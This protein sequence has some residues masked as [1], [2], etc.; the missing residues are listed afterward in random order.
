MAMRWITKAKYFYFN[1]FNWILQSKNYFTSV[2]TN[3][4][5]K[6]EKELFMKNI[7]E[8]KF[9]NTLQNLLANKKSKKS[10]QKS[11]F[12]NKTLNV[13]VIPVLGTGKPFLILSF[14]SMNFYINP[15]GEFLTHLYDI[16]RIP[17]ASSIL[18]TNCSY[19][20]A[21][22]VMPSMLVNERLLTET[23]NVFGPAG[24]RTTFSKLMPRLKSVKACNHWKSKLIYH[25]PLSSGVLE[26]NKNPITIKMLSCNYKA[27]PYVVGY[28]FEYK[29]PR[30]KKLKVSDKVFQ[31]TW[32]DF[33]TVASYMEYVKHCRN[34]TL[35]S[36]PE[37]E[38]VSFGVLDFS[39]QN[40]FEHF[41]NV[42]YS[43][44]EKELKKVTCCIHIMSKSLF[45]STKYTTWL[46]KL[47][48]CGHF[49]VQDLFRFSEFP[50]KSQNYRAFLHTMHPS[51]FPLYSN[52]ES[53]ENLI[54]AMYGALQSCQS[55]EIQH[56]AGQSNVKLQQFYD[57]SLQRI[58]Q[59]LQKCQKRPAFQRFQSHEL[60]PHLV[61]L[62]S[63][64]AMTSS[65]RKPP[66]YLLRITEKSSILIDCGSNTVSQLIAHYGFDLA[67][68]I[69]STVRAV[70]LT[71]KH[72]DH[73]SGF[74]DLVLKMHTA[75][76][77]ERPLTAVMPEGLKQFFVAL[78]KKDL[79]GKIN[80]ES[81]ESLV[82]RGPAYRDS[83]AKSLDLKHIT[84]VRVD[85]G[86][87]TYGIV[88]NLRNGQ[89]IAYSSDTLP[90][91]QYLIQKGM[92]CDILIHDS[93]YLSE[94]D[95]LMA[96]VRMHSTVNGAI[97]TAEKMNAKTLLLTHFSNKYSI[98]PLNV[99]E[100][101][102][103]SSYKGNILASLDHLEL[104]LSKVKDYFRLLEDLSAVFDEELKK[105]SEVFKENRTNEVHCLFDK[106][107]K[108]YATAT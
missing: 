101:T 34:L 86:P 96:D 80:F 69:C 41:S 93:L 42:D 78:E 55:V 22:S 26:I 61:V 72:D 105:S 8:H 73:W 102:K 10:E 28:T 47:G 32:K 75:A 66:C 87:P 15:H 36:I 45:Y 53:V 58:I 20:V 85:H 94:S 25:E 90:E 84:P 18:F 7:K 14:G 40:I 95:K 54:E 83:L 17:L 9:R 35:K 103:N 43:L 67:M 46:R 33:H 16:G 82:S 21:L 30:T 19:E 49:L 106:L 38:T 50:Q 108:S 98:L 5:E 104:P 31:K 13:Q 91:S 52:K 79:F 100:T 6:N 44:L 77:F 76:H 39:E 29:I 70:F 24:I 51:F 107:N 4:S 62:G 92:D 11:F 57:K 99:A 37:S 63:G 60:F 68:K 89:K 12:W 64:S 59:I 56:N 27:K 2:V 65:F 3:G 97:S 1:N 71:H 48:I 81:F 88:I 74:Y 23:L